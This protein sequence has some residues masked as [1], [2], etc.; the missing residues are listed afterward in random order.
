MERAAI[1]RLQK[2]IGD[3]IIAKGIEIPKRI[4]GWWYY[5]EPIFNLNVPFEEEIVVL[6]PAFRD[7]GPARVIIVPL[8]IYENKKFRKDFSLYS[9]AVSVCENPEII[10]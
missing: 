8:L 7:G 5:W 4:Y 10:E 3:M 9:S 6:A 2:E 1:R